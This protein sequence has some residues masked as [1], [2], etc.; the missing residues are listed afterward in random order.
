[1]EYIIKVKIY[2]NQC[3]VAE[4]K[5]FISVF[6]SYK[7]HIIIIDN[8]FMCWF[9]ANLKKKV[10]IAKIKDNKLNLIK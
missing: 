9:L 8:F 2:L 10:T 7:K 3:V 5:I 4:F 1:M 6:L